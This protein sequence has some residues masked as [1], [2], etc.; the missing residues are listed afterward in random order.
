MERTEVAS[1]WHQ[2]AHPPLCHCLRPAGLPAGF[3]ETIQTDCRGLELVHL[4]TLIDAVTQPAA[5]GGDG[6]SGAAA[7]AGEAPAAALS[8]ALQSALG[9]SY[10]KKL[11]ELADN[12]SSS[13]GSGAAGAGRGSKAEGLLAVFGPGLSSPAQLQ[14][15]LGS[16]AELAS[17]AGQQAREATLQ[18]L[19]AAAVPAALWQRCASSSLR[20][21]WVAADA[22]GGQEEQ[23]QVLP[24]MQAVMRRHCPRA[25]AAPLAEL[26]GQ[27]DMAQFAARL[28]LP[29]APQQQQVQQ[30]GAPA[31]EE[32][33]EGC[34]PQP[35]SADDN[36]LD[37]LK[38]LVANLDGHKGGWVGGS[39]AMVQVERMAGQA[40]G[41]LLQ[42]LPLFAVGAVAW[43][44]GAAGSPL[45]KSFSCCLCT[46]CCCLCYCCREG[47]G[48]GAA[49]PAGPAPPAGQA[50]AARDAAGGG[51]PRRCAGGQQGPR[52][53]AE[54]AAH[55]G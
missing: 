43:H 6:S 25:A 37:S 28:A 14:A 49:A 42:S 17:G 29:T 32:D 55:A 10:L 41:L 7:A 11:Q 54:C 45:C 5:D 16:A 12:D 31:E 24:A 33:D 2:L 40:A 20:V 19:L 9:S 21:C 35:A 53:A 26:A 30:Q 8:R 39:G 1:C 52:A 4:L 23:L 22:A 38:V 18:R 46:C 27:C 48:G 44:H 50:A 34:W 51:A 47:G 3:Q 13:G 15:F 36:A